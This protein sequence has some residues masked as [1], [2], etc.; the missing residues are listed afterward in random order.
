MT[1][2]SNQNLLI[3]AIVLIVI[4]A[5]LFYA[6]IPY[7]GWN[8]WEHSDHYWNNCLS[9]LDCVNGYCS[10]KAYLILF[11]GQFALI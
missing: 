9:Y 8:Y 10:H 4:G 3:L 1:G 11:T 7:P 6:P 5:V 2:I